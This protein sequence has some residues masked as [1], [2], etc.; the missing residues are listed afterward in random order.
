VRRY[1]AVSL[2]ALSVS[3]PL[4]YLVLLALLRVPLAVVVAVVSISVDFI[5]DDTFTCLLSHTKPLQTG[6][7]KTTLASTPSPPLPV[8]L[9]CG[10]HDTD[11]SELIPER[12]CRSELTGKVPGGEL[13]ILAA[14]ALAAV[15]EESK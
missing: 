9:V 7:T 8:A 15:T 10:L 1:T 11:C 4:K 6:Q 12:Y 5:N 2:D 3:L 14:V 13:L